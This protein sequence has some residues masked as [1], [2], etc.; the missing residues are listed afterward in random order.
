MTLTVW[1]FLVEE[2]TAFRRDSVTPNPPQPRIGTTTEWAKRELATYYL[3]DEPWDWR[4]DMEENGFHQAMVRSKV[5]QGLRAGRVTFFTPRTEADIAHL[6][7]RISSAC[8]AQ[9]IVPICDIAQ[10]WAKEMK[11]DACIYTNHLQIDLEALSEAVETSKHKI[12]SSA[13]AKAA[14]PTT[15]VDTLK[16]EDPGIETRGST[17]TQAWRERLRKRGRD[18]IPLGPIPT[19]ANVYL[20][21]G[22]FFNVK[23]DTT[24]EQAIEEGKSILKGLVAV[25]FKKAGHIIPNEIQSLASTRV[26]LAQKASSKEGTMSILQQGVRYAYHYGVDC[27]YITDYI[28]VLVLKIPERPVE[29]GANKGKYALEWATVGR[30]DARLL[31]A[32]LLWKSIHHLAQFLKDAD[33]ERVS[34]ATA[35]IA[36]K[37]ADL[38]LP[39]TVANRKRG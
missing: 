38:K 37:Q 11:L 24:L 12:D 25:E 7:S 13:V 9:I 1:D 10:S 20:K 8:D 29:K 6:M 15:R 19:S 2:P 18:E 34:D 28:T 5:P 33:D 17:K 32:Y 23:A 14:K 35:E 39:Q 3:D 27:V 36:K 31:L 26:S 16:F 30:K 22:E 21:S 4:A